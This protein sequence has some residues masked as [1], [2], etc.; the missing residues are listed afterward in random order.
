[1]SCKIFPESLEKEPCQTSS[2]LEKAAKTLVRN[3][4]I[5][6]NLVK[7]YLAMVFMESIKL[8]SQ[9]EDSE[10]GFGR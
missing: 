1:M 7:G 3:E 4:K 8:P 5:L 10:A 6:H 2:A 9:T